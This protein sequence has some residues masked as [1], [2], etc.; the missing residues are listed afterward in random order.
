MSSRWLIHIV[1]ETSFKGGDTN[2]TNSSDI[3]GQS[4]TEQEF[5]AC[6]SSRH[7]EGMFVLNGSVSG[8]Q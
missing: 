7:A 2:D 8:V 6:R 1:L 3:G 5:R 4:R